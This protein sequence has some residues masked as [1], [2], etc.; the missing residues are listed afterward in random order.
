MAFMP[1]LPQN[2]PEDRV[3]ASVMGIFLSVFCI[4]LAVGIEFVISGLKKRRYWAWLAALIACCL[5]LPSLFFVLGGLGLWGL[6]DPDTRA[7]FPPPG[8]TPPL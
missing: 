5:Y 7:A 1:L 6:I 8:Q 4:L 2:T 3:F